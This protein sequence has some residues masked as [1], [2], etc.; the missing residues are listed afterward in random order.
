MKL[1]SLFC[2]LF[3]T[4]MVSTARAV[5]P[6]DLGSAGQFTILA[7]T[8]ISTTGVT[9]IVGDI[10]LSPAAASFITGFGLIMDPSTQFATSSLINGKAYASDFSAP[11]PAKMT[12]AIGD[13]QTAYTSAAGAAAGSTNLNG[14]TLTNLTLAPGVYAWGT[15]VMIT[16]NLTLSGTSS[17]V[18][19]FQIAGTLDV[20][21]GIQIILS[22]GAQVTNVFWQVAGQTTL[23]TTSV[24]VGNIL[25]QTAI[26][27][28]TGASL[29]GR[30]LAQSAV[31]LDG[32]SVVS[33]Q[34]SGA[35][36]P[37]PGKTF[38]FPSPAR[39]GVI[40]MVYNMQGPGHVKVRIYNDHGDLA[41]SLEEDKPE[42]P[43]SSQ[44]QI[45]A[46]APGVYLYKVVVQYASGASE[47]LAV[48]KFGVIR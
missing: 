11:T 2:A 39:G 46:F 41:A 44:F 31:T 22:G 30:A 36:A 38:A 37:N 35:N 20:S 4:L 13:M 10:G 6:V 42:G 34:Y 47:S 14:G 48:Q 15:N 8:G 16:G 24:F 25:D 3:L 33:Y 40:N 45:G 5:A 17:D 12:A 1:S 19:I 18:W 7:K 26:V 28:N 43:Q 29:K 23:G 32:N 27:M 9:S 21:S